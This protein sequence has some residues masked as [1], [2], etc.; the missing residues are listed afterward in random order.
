M[1]RRYLHTM[2]V[3]FLILLGS[4]GIHDAVQAEEPDPDASPAAGTRH[5]VSVLEA[6][7]DF[8]SNVF[9]LDS[10]KKSDLSS[11]SDSDRLSGRFSDMESASDLI[12]TLR[13]T[14]G[15]KTRA[16]SDRSL[17]FTPGMRYELYTHNSERS[18]LRLDLAV[19]QALPN[20]GRLNLVGR[21]TPSYF[22]KNYLADATDLDSSGTI[23]PDERLY[24]AGVYSEGDVM[25]AYRARLAK[26]TR[27]HPFGVKLQ[28][29]LGYYSRVYDTPFRG[30]DLKGPTGSVDLLLDLSRHASL[31]V[32]Y[33]F[34]TLSA[35][36]AS[37]VL[38]L[39]E[40]D[41]GQ[42]FN[43][44]GSADDLDVRTE[45][46]VDRSRTEQE[47]GAEVDL[48]L[49][50]TTRV[51]LFYEYRLRDFA[52]ELPFDILNRG[53][54]DTRHS[55]GLDVSFRPAPGLRVSLE[56]E[57]ASQGTNRAGDPGSTGEIDDYG[58]A[59]TGFKLAYRL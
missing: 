38:L 24:R 45:Q 50:G 27:D 32:A 13:L 5:F 58:R 39:D 2:S 28:L 40:P 35:N 4:V 29:G 18:N 42:D 30:R 7:M 17:T 55:A 59:R 49:A 19:T 9:L 12:T 46:V 21:L 37:E 56:G 33:G 54:R 3:S 51:R 26:S 14:G 44:D 52:S 41:F 43:G 6:R 36:E 15:L 31:D 8:D 16:L 48:E 23:S 53:R 34:S 11:P 25:L 57:F 47:L 10:S 22:S 1:V 20:G